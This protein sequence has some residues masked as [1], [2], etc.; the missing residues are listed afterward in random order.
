MNDWGYGD[1]PLVK[2]M[3]EWLTSWVCNPPTNQHRYRVH[4]DR[5]AQD[6]RCTP[7]AMLVNVLATYALR[8][9][10]PPNA[11]HPAESAFHVVLGSRFI[12]TAGA[13]SERP[14]WAK[15]NVPVSTW[16]PEGTTCRTFGEAIHEKLGPSCVALVQSIDRECQRR[17]NAE[18]EFKTLLVEQ[19]LP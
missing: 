13:A 8:W 14:A 10:G 11:L 19:P 9:I 2:K 6:P 4:L 7:R 17:I 15:A 1:L 3:E 16:R 5:M 18:N 12:R